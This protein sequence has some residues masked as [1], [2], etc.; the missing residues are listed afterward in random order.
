MQAKA[1]GVTHLIVGESSDLIFGGMDKLLA[2]DWTMEEFEK[3]YTFLDPTLVLKEP[4]SMHYLFDI[5]RSR[6]PAS[7]KLCSLLNKPDRRVTEVELD[8]VGFEIPDKFVVGYGLD[9]AQKYRNLPY[10]GVVTLD[11]DK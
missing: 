9:Y 8:Y 6:G 10:I 7:L 4:V 1:D 5:L 2:K 3:R 11:E